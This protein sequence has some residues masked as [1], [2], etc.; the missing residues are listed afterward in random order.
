[1]LDEYK[2]WFVACAVGF[3]PVKSLLVF[4]FRNI[5]RGLEQGFVAWY[6]I[7]PDIDLSRRSFRR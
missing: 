2:L 3:N 4:A 1:M 5:Q 6:E 7:N